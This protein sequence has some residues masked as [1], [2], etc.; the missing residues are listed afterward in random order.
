M[1]LRERTRQ[2]SPQSDQASSGLGFSGLES[3]EAFDN[4]PTAKE[5]C[6]PDRP[7]ASIYSGQ[8]PQGSAFELLIQS[9]LESSPTF[10]PDGRPNVGH[11]NDKS[12][13]IMRCFHPLSMFLQS[14]AK[15][16]S[17]IGGCP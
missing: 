4:T 11:C 5:L 13:M 1:G 14:L 17:G 10:T 15:D 7:R 6:L 2:K 12:L 16:H 8:G 3:T 9:A